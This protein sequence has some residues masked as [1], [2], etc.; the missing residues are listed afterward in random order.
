MADTKPI[1]ALRIRACQESFW[2]AGRK[3]TREAQTVPAS[4]FTKAQLAQ[5]RSEPLL[6]VED[7]TIAPQ[8][9][10]E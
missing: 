3:W 5:L 9:E 8:G 6:V 7:T 2:R 4:D 1:P 10:V